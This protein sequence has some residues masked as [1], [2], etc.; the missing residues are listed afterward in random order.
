[1]ST[2]LCS[3]TCAAFGSGRTLKA[4]M[5][6]FDAWASMT[7]DSVTPPTAPCTTFTRT[8]SVV[9]FLSASLIASTD[10]WT[11]PLMMSERSLMSPCWMR[12]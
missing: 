9:C 3:A 11:S 7:S 12:A 6:A 8:A 2:P 1:M 5:I 10:P 4:M